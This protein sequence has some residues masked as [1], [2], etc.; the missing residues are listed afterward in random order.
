MDG[1]APAL[2]RSSPGVV[3]VVPDGRVAQALEQ[4]RAV[5]RGADDASGYFPAMYAHVT[6]AVQ[7]R[8]AAGGFADPARMTDLTTTFA[9]LYLDAVQD[10]PAAPGCWRAT[11]DVA[12]DPRLLVAQHLFLGI[13][14]HVNH[15]LPQ[16]VVAVADRTGDLA[17]LRPDF[18]AVNALL[19]EAYGEVTGALDRVARWTSEA[20]A[21]GG[22]RLFGFS[23]TVARDQAWGAAE[24]LHRLDPAG[25][26]AYVRELDRLV[27]VL[28]CLVAQPP[29]LSARVLLPVLRRCEVREPRRV[30]AVL[31]GATDG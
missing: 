31:L 8:L 13:N 5:A 17:A 20:A 10:R 2:R 16:A 7:E 24:R 1:E 18:D 3:P 26:A 6:A 11:W 14:A 9:G 22:G 25:R 4:L 30:T 29:G 12:D 27:S 19:A 23:L 21:L 28:A 15:D